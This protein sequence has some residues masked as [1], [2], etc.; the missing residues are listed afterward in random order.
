MTKSLFVD[1]AVKRLQGNA[2]DKCLHTQLTVELAGSEITLDPE[3]PEYHRA[4]VVESEI[5]SDKGHN[6]FL[7]FS[8]GNQRS[9]RILSMKSANALLFLPQGPGRVSVGTKLTSL[10]IGPLQP[11][12]K[13]F[14]VH[15]QAAEIDYKSNLG[16]VLDSEGGGKGDSFHPT[17]MTERLVVKVGLLTISDR[18][19]FYS[20]FV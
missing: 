1:P 15:Q 11:P 12:C 19:R 10:L 5:H 7:A 13:N 8:T 2:S 4:T 9:S 20:L 17:E 18:V 16:C 3:R 14:S 6:R